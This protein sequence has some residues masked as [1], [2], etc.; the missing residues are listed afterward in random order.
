MANELTQSV[1]IDSTDLLDEHP[2]GFAG[3]L[4]FGTER[5]R[6]GTE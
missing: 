3:D 1:R 6:T 5:C 4:N 2:C